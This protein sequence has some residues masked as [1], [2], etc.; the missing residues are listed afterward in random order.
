MKESI[1]PERA[2]ISASTESEWRRPFEEAHINYLAG[3]QDTWIDLHRRVDE[4]A[5]ERCRSLQKAATQEDPEK[6]AAAANETFLRTVLDVW[7]GTEQQLRKHYESYLSALQRAWS[8]LDLKAVDVC[9]LA[10]IGNSITA[11][12]AT[13]SCPGADPEIVNLVAFA[14]AQLANTEEA[15]SAQTA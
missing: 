6:S 13:A 8:G 9:S 4:A 2:S 10:M 15:S 14:S 1:Q 7:T 12:A 11:A 3:V 5:R